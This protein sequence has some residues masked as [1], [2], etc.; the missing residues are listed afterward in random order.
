MHRLE[1]S[2][3]LSSLGET[4]KGII[5]NAC[6]II[7]DSRRDFHLTRKSAS[8]R[9]P[10]STMSSPGNTGGRY[11]SGV[12]FVCKSH[13]CYPSL[14]NQE[15]KTA[16]K[17]SGKHSTSDSQWTRTKIE[18]KKNMYGMGW[19]GPLQLKEDRLF[20]QFPTRN[21]MKALCLGP[22]CWNKTSKGQ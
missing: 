1:I 11:S 4:R 22:C 17:P 8:C 2:H 21:Q 15:T 10:S 19:I 3:V 9:L 14:G 12:F 18:I 13:D 16:S 5:N 6:S 7:Q 20:K